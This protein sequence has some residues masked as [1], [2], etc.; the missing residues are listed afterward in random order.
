MEVMKN[1][2]KIEEVMD[3][4]EEED[5]VQKLTK[6][7][8]DRITKVENESSQKE[9]ENDTC[10]SCGKKF[11]RLLQ[12]IKVNKKCKVSEQEMKKID[13]RSKIIRKEKNRINN[14]KHREKLGK[15]KVNKR[16][17]E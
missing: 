2:A 9:K 12:H 16:N 8:E 4:L 5:E 6:F 11:A 10:P 15:V 17:K 7:K 1:E 14:L 3:D 13:E